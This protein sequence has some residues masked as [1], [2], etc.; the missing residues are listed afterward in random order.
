MKSA[1]GVQ[2]ID[3][4][5]LNNSGTD[6]V[7][8]IAEVGYSGPEKTTLNHSGVSGEASQ[9]YSSEKNEALQVEKGEVKDDKK[10]DA[11]EKHTEVRKSSDVHLNIRLPNGVS[12]KQ[13]FSVTSTVRMVKHYVDENQGSGLGTYDLA[14]PYPRKV[15]SNQGKKCWR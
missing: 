6:N 9:A 11:F 15:F 5:D 2:D 7:S 4:E 3:M 13:K 8:S 10:V 1:Q 14:I 12:L